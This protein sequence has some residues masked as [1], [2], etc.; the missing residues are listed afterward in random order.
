MKRTPA[1]S[2][3]DVRKRHQAFFDSLDVFIKSYLNGSSAQSC[4]PSASRCPASEASV[5]A[6]R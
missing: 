4:D 5:K 2:V 3:P 6:R 1:A